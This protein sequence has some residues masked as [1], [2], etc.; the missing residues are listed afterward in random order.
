MG[1]GAVKV[2]GSGNNTLMFR[3]V[4]LSYGKKTRNVLTLTP[5]VETTRGDLWACDA[6]NATL[7][8]RALFISWE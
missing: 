5:N 1:G 7:D 2:C 4:G 6:H 8:D 3:N